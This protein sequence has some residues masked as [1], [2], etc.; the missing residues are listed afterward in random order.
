[1]VAR[2][3]DSMAARGITGQNEHVE[4][5]RDILPTSAIT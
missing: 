1:M 5:Q 2:E 3:G 4:F